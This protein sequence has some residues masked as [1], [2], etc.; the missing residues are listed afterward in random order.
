M[1]RIKITESQ[2]KHILNEKYGV[3]VNTEGGE[4]PNPISYGTETSISDK[5]DGEYSDVFTDDKIKRVNQF[6]F[7]RARYYGGMMENKKKS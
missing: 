1:R 7:Y 4:K 5:M 3:Y 2:L 6:P